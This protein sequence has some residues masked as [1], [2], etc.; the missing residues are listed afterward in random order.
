MTALDLAWLEM[1][2]NDLRIT[3][4]AP[5]TLYCDNIYAIVLTVNSV[6]HARTKHI[7]VDYHFVR[8]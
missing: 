2:L 1:L 7:A 8:E 4:V 3:Q 6:F 5:P